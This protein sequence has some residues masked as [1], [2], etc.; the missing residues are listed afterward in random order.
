MYVSNQKTPQSYVPNTVMGQA[1][2]RQ[3]R[4]LSHDTSLP[5]LQAHGHPHQAPEGRTGIQDLFAQAQYSQNPSHRP[6]ISIEPPLSDFKPS[7]RIVGQPQAS[8]KA[9]LLNAYKDQMR[10][11]EETKKLDK[12]REKQEELKLLAEQDRYQYFGK[13]IYI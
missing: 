1:G 11:K 7:I 12:L 5:N 2:A 3:M 10:L 13:Y 4:G 9:D 6:S 8:P